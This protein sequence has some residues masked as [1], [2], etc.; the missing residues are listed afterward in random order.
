MENEYNN[1]YKGME[2]ISL[3]KEVRMAER[4]NNGRD[5]F[6]FT[7]V[8]HYGVLSTSSRG[9]TKELN[10]VSWNDKPPKFDIREWDQE[11]NR[12]SRGVTLTRDEIL[13]LADYIAGQLSEAV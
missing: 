5:D 11:H 4:E 1:H 7:I 12:M 6:R 10:S 3:G 8:K 9:W 13:Q 2:N